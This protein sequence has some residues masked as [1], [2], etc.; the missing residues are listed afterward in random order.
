MYISYKLSRPN[1][2]V[3]SLILLIDNCDMSPD[4]KRGVLP[5]NVHDRKFIRVGK[6]IYYANRSGEDIWHS[7]LAKEMGIGPARGR[8]I[9]DDG[10]T[11]FNQEEKIAFGGGYTTIC[12]IKSDPRKAREETKKIAREILGEKKVF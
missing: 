5:E 3:D 7:D 6:R 1:K 8:P 9:V 12:E 11:L 2:K 4:L 10:G